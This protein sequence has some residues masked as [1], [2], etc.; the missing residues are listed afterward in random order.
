MATQTAQDKI[1][2]QVDKERAEIIT[3][4]FGSMV[5]KTISRVRPMT[6]SECDA[7]GWEYNY[8]GYFPMVVVFSDGTGFVPMADP[9]GNSQG[10]MDLVK[11]G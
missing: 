8:G 4:D 2:Y 3:R 11:L 10:F 6:Q 9:E 7:F 1:K 5:G